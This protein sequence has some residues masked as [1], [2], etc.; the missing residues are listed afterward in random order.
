MKK[1][2]ITRRQAFTLTTAFLAFGT[3]HARAANSALPAITAYR[4][5]GCGCCEK[6]AAMLQQSG[7]TITMQDDEDLATRKTKA[8]VPDDLAGC[9]TAFM[10]DYIIEGHVPLLDIMRLVTEA[11]KIKGLAVPGMP[12]GSPGMETDQT[13]DHYDVVA[14]TADGNR[15]TFSAY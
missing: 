8:G 6:W 4:N 12:M 5:P 1:P 14:F 7:F 10:G 3:S 11:P 13:A 9:H 2:K 15:E